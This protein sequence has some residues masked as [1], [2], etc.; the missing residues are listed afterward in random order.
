MII[1]AGK[2][3]REIYTWAEQAIAAG[4]PLR[5]KGF[6]DSRTTVLDGFTYDAK[7]LGAVDTYEIEEDDVFIG[8]IGDP[9]QKRV[10]YSPVGERGGQFINLIHP[11]AV[12]GSNVQLGSGIVMAPFSVITADVRIG[13]H[14]TIG[15]FS[16]I[17]HDVVIG[18][19]CQ[20]SSH[21]GVNGWRI[22]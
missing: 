2:S 13:N 16:N 6:L 5:I 19:W 17:G 22:A 20:I 12:I 1:G 10:Y 15:S 11:S 14:V 3:G 8:A 7:I 4:Q 18:D 9:R 21:C